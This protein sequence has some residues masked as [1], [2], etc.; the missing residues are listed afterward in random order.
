MLLCPRA[1]VAMETQ[2][3]FQVFS[4]ACLGK[5]GCTHL[6]IIDFLGIVS[7]TTVCS[8]VENPDLVVYEQKCI[9]LMVVWDEK[10]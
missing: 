5:E 9:W 3:L 4:F 2:V 6:R 7:Y 10:S 1:S 8:V